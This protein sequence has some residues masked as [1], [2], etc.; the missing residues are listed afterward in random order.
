MKCFT[1]LLGTKL[2]HSIFEH[3]ARIS[4]ITW[5]ITRFRES[6]Q[7]PN[8]NPLDEDTSR[9]YF[10]DALQGLDYRKYEIF[11]LTILPWPPHFNTF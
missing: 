2:W 9:R 10:R 4:F 5:P 1:A 11:N 3:I 6:L 8:D 7:I